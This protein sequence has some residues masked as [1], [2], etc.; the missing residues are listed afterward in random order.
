MFPTRPMSYT[1]EETDMHFKKK[2]QIFAA[3]ICFVLAFSIT[4]Q[5]K[6]VTKN[7]SMGIKEAKRVEDL[8]NQ[9]INANE[10]IVDLKK[11]NMQLHS[12]IDIYRTDAASK[13]SGS[14]ALKQELEKNL[15][16]SGFVTVE[17][18][19]VEITISD[20]TENTS[21]TDSNDSGIVH[22]T[23]IRSVINELYGAG[24]EVISVNSERLVAN[25][26][27]RCVGNTIMINNKRC[28]SPFTIKAIGNADELES[29]LSIR[30]GVL[31]VL[32]LY[33]I[34]VNVTKKSSGIK[35]DKYTGVVEYTHAK[36]S[37]KQV[38]E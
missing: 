1:K 32:K 20:S 38:T 10:Q 17:G 4:L 8:E 36:K 16:I 31:D 22:D 34:Q 14:N 5:Y 13:D 18:P 27:I 33:K 9:L 6:S 19:G 11:E 37:E 23:D 29:A 30:G 2:V 15:L 28:S 21:Q 3:I 26:A 12:D 24:A 25:S 7:N 35:I